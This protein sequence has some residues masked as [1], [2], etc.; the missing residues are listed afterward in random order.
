MPVDLLRARRRRQFR[1]ADRLN[2]AVGDDDGAVVDLPPL[3]I[4][5][6]RVADD[7]RHARIAD[8]GRRIGIL[9]DRDR[10]RPLGFPPARAGGQQERSGKRRRNEPI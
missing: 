3:A 2:D 7:R 4:E 1:P 6:R 9:V 8:V 5:H 10:R